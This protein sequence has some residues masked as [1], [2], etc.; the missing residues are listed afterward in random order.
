M[1]EYAAIVFDYVKKKYISIWYT[2]DSMYTCKT[3]WLWN[4]TK[5]HNDECKV[6]RPTDMMKISLD[7]KRKAM[8]EGNMSKP[9]ENTDGEITQ[10][11]ST[12]LM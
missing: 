1:N 12:L 8:T 6:D 11:T 3:I 4:P 2:R 9:L 7:C 10:G 5:I